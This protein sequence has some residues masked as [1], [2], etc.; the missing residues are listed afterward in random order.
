MRPALEG[1]GA[2][3]TGYDK[4]IPL[5]TLLAELARDREER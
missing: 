1:P 3:P 2:P 4:Q 5:A